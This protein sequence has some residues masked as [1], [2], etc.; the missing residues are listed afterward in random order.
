MRV[1]FLFLLILFQLGLFA[2]LQFEEYTLDNGLTVILNPD[3]TATKVAGAV[4]VN[5]GSKN[6]PADAS[7]IS[8]YLEHLLFKGTKTLGTANYEKEKPHLDSINILYDKLAKAEEESKRLA[9][10]QLINEQA[11]KAAE[12]GMPN[13]FDRLVKSIGGTG[14]NATTNTDLT[15]YYNNFP[16]EQLNK[17]LDLYAH[18]FQ[19]PVFRS[20]QSELEV[21]YEEKNRA[22]D[23]MQRNVQEYF[24]KHLYEG[25]PY[26]ENNTLGKVEH[27]KNPPL[28]RMYEYFNKYYVAKNMA[29]ILSGNFDVKEAKPIIAEKFGRLK[30]GER[31]NETY[32]EPKPFDGRVVLKKRLTPIKVGVMGF[33]TVPDFHEDYQALEVLA[34]ILQNEAGTGL[35]DRLKNNNKLMMAFSYSSFLD[36]AGDHTIVFVPKVIGQSFK[37]AENLVLEQLNKL[38]TGDF[39]NDLLQV[40]RSEVYTSA[41]KRQE[42]IENR[43]Y[44]IASYFRNNRPLSN[45]SSD[46]ELYKQ[47]SKD[48]VVRV[49]KKYFG[50]NYLLLK[51][52][53]GFP[54]KEKL[55]KPSYKAVKANQARKS[56]YAT[57]FDSL[58]VKEPEPKFIDLEKDINIVKLGATSKLF[59]VKNP[60]NQLYELKL[61]FHGGTKEEPMQEVLAEVMQYAYPENESYQSFRNQFYKRGSSI[62]FT[63]TNSF[64]EIELAGIDENLESDL[65]ALSQLFNS[66]LIEGKAI[67]SAYNTFKTQRKAEQEEAVLLAK[68]LALYGLYGEASPLLQRIPY[69]DIK[70]IEAET[71]QALWKKIKSSALHVH[72]SGSLNSAKVRALLTPLKINKEAQ[73][74]LPYPI[75]FRSQS[76]S[77]I[78]LLNNKK[79]LQSHLFYIK[80]GNAFKL[81]QSPTQ[82]AFNLYFDDGFSGI[83]TQEVREYRSLAYSTSAKLKYTEEKNPKNYF[84]TYVGCQADKANEASTLTYQLIQDMPKKPDR[85]KEA[86]EK[87]KLQAATSFPNFRQLSERAES[88]VLM[89]FKEDPNQIRYQRIE[90]LTFEKM[91]NHYKKEIAQ[92]PLFLGIYGDIDK[93]DHSELKK[94]G[95][96][97][98]IELQESITF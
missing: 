71:L 15:I 36:E 18:R 2:Q 45:L 74:P 89:G 49:A 59:A 27:L 56:V 88:M 39:S 34:S 58:E 61:K 6:D 94:M 23:D 31:A 66:T 47:V 43:G 82:S 14:V 22:M 10:Q 86:I 19:D 77:E 32:P 24:A 96:V 53:T 98:E 25:H 33:H 62:Y 52:R 40:A 35:I 29:L 3:P 73:S 48:D 5:T 51:S 57:H 55:E 75:K 4:A 26:G 21:V 50:D 11:I 69:K 92:P 97:N 60:I 64:F 28:F 41:L 87:A 63:A 54:K 65:T 76:E 20:F 81:E 38:K 83:L 67:K 30:A 78:L 70:K 7:G 9:I 12:Y 79:L 95:K 37:R 68:S 44:L 93:I 85:F 46:L 17:W 91:Y 84:F 16:A 1:S 13:E 8:H 42:S 90:K 80:K 72:Y